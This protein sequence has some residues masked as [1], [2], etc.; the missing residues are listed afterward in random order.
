MSFLTDDELNAVQH[1][2]RRAP[3]AITGISQGF[4]S[5]ARHYGG[6]KYQ[7]CSYTY[8]SGADE[9]VRDDVFKL[10]MK[11]RRKPRKVQEQTTLDIG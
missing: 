5:I 3:Y 11:M 9:C 10:V 6:M 4:F 1:L 7:D 8:V 2:H